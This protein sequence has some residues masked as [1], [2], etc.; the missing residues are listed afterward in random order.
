MLLLTRRIAQRAGWAWPLLMNVVI[1][2]LEYSLY[3]WGHSVAVLY[4]AQL[5]RG[6]SFALYV[7]SR[8]QYLHLLAPEGMEASTQALVNS[9]TAFVTFLA[10]AAG[11]FLL[12]A[13][14]T[15]SFFAMLCGLQLI[16]GLF[17]VGLHVVGTKVLHRPLRSTACMLT[18]QG[19]GKEV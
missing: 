8:Y 9:V 15:R 16:S 17:F 1:L 7:T 13:L 2:A 19:H 11:G 3:A 6:F 14:G 4:I 5:F 18:L 12:E 10:A